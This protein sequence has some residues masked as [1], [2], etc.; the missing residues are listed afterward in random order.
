MRNCSTSNSGKTVTRSLPPL[1]ARTMS[2]RRSRSRSLTRRQSNSVKRNPLPYMS[3]AI[4]RGTPSKAEKSRWHSS[5]V[6]TTGT[7]ITLRARVKLPKSPSG[8]CKASRKR[9]TRAFKAC[10]C[11]EAEAR[12][13]TARSV[14]KSFTSRWAACSHRPPRASSQRTK[15][16]AHSRYACSVRQA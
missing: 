15:R 16:L 10:F 4:S 2:W 14:R 12:C 3:S 7:R 11:A 8:R 5:R 6:S 13:R 9:K 1:P